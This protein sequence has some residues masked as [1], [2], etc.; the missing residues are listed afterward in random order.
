MMYGVRRSMLVGLLLVTVLT[1]CRTYGGY[2]SEE[3]TNAQIQAAV[4]QLTQD[5]TQAEAD[6]RLLQ[7][8]AQSNPVLQSLAAD[9]D[10]LLEAHRQAVAAAGEGLEMLSDDSYPLFRRAMN[11]YYRDL[12]RKLGSIVQYQAQV[13]EQYLALR[14]E[15]QRA[16]QGEA[17]EDVA[18]KGRYR[19]A[20]P[21]YERIRLA[22][23]TPTMAEALGQG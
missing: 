14:L 10:V 23:E 7:T 2:D 13:D 9:Y 16:V 20:P 18:E 4:D 8:A 6:H 5:L 15:V 12:N 17:A 22:I 19:F 11:S 3:L 1:G 21:Y